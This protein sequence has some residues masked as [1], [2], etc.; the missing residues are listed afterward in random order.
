V[1][2][3]VI[4]PVGDPRGGLVVGDCLLHFLKMNARISQPVWLLPALHY[5]VRKSMHTD[6]IVIG[7][8]RNEEA[9]HRCDAFS[10]TKSRASLSISS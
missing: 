7:G 8:E 5:Q 3:N 6:N 9:E 10:V 1:A 4:G 2:I